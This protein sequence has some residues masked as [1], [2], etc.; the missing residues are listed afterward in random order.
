MSNDLQVLRGYNRPTPATIAY[1]SPGMILQGTAKAAQKF[2]HLFLREYD[3][4]RDRGTMFPILL[5]TG[6]LQTDNA[7]VTNFTAA[8]LRITRQ[9]GDQSS[10]PANEQIAR[11]DLISHTI[12]SDNL[13]LTVRL[14][15][16]DGTTQFI[17]PIERV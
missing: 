15:T 10:L 12:F 8:V 17:L 3:A 14:T 13:S 9:L 2:A 4:V 7:I 11:A 6:Q 5:K 1:A 16:G